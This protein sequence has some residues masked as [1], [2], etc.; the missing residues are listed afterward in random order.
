MARLCPLFSGSKG[1]SYYIGSK[2]AGILVDAGRSAKQLDLMLKTCG[3]DPLAVQ[4]IF[5]T[6]EHNDHVSALRVFAKRYRLPVFASKGTL[7]ALAGSLE[8]TPMHVV[9]DSLQIA[10]LE[11]HPFHTSHDCAEP[12]GFRVRTQDERI[13]T[14]CTDLG[15][16][17]EEVTENLLG[18]DFVV[19][20][21]NHDVEMLRTGPYPYY[22]QQR[23][24]SDCGHLSN[25][26]CAA[27]LPRLA[28][29]GTRRILLAHL[30][31]ENNS[32]TL[33][34]E[35]AMRALVAEG[36]IANEDFVLDAAR[37]ANDTGA[38]IRF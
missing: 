36:L 18:A 31:N 25:D 32:R 24:L 37:P 38:V 22:L 1:N 13:I 7:A 9:E 3:I 19:L 28:K 14:V 8:D 29:S 33:A 21:S 2:S 17:S 35:T 23:I 30:S 4:G 5:I 16:L 12:L 11:V 20:E 15:C 10:G 26:V 27:L 34:L 6:H